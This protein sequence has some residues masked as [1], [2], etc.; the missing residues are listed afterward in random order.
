MN[1]KSDWD[2]K[3]HA[4]LWAYRI[5]YK[6]GTE[7]TPFQ[8]VYGLEVVVPIEFVVPSLR[9]ACLMR[10]DDQKSLEERLMNLN[11]LDEH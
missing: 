4:I 9:I 8:L 1:D 11:R 2:D 10:W 7:Y 3:V 6:K 5:A